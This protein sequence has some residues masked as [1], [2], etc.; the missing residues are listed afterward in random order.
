MYVDRS[1]LVL[2]CRAVTEVASD[3]ESP[4]PAKNVIGL[5]APFLAAQPPDVCSQPAVHAD[6]ATNSAEP[7][8][9]EAPLAEQA[10]VQ[11][12]ISQQQANGGLYA[13]ASG[14]LERLLSTGNR[15]LS[16]AVLESL[17]TLEAAVQGEPCDGKRHVDTSIVLLHMYIAALVNT[18]GD[19]HS[20]QFCNN[21]QK[22]SNDWRPNK[23]A[24]WAQPAVCL[25]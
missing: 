16:S 14:L 6:T 10:E 8:A 20:N 23:Q 21:L 7:S 5:L 18:T 12:F 17:L 11:K 24:L 3:H 19:M 13:V 22:S 9:A 4:E 1:N 15:S 2:L 25:L